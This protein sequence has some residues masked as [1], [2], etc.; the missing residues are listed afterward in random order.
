MHTRRRFGVAVLAAAGVLVLAGSDARAGM[1]TVTLTWPGHTLTIVAGGGFATGP[2]DNSSLTFLTGPL[3]TFLTANGSALQFTAG[4]GAASN[5]PGAA[6][7]TGAT[8][9]QTGGI[10]VNQASAGSTT[11]TIDAYLT[12]YTTPSGTTGTV[13]S[14]GNAT[15][16]LTAAGDT[17]T[18][19]SWYNNDNSV[20]GMLLPSGLITWTSTGP[21]PNSPIPV[22]PGGTQA[23]IPAFQTPFSLTNEI[24]VTLTKTGLNG[25]NDQY[26]GTTTVTAAPLAT[27]VPEPASLILLGLGGLGLLGYGWRKRRQAA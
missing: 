12:D 11:M 10:T 7:P 22:P 27:G 23:P 5:F 9:S 6:D 17:Q 20:R 2:A 1:L 14:A 18:F 24:T 25:E 26:A 15:F 21:I 4:S 3:N 16:G 13:A 19:N 8:L